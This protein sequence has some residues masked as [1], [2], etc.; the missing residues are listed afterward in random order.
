MAA[1]EEH[2]AYKAQL[3]REA[4]QA[5]AADLA[6]LLDPAAGD[7]PRWAGCMADLMEAAHTAYAE[8]CLRDAD[9]EPLP[10]KQI[11]EAACARLGL[12][13]PSN[14]RSMASRAGNRKGMR[15]ETL[16]ARYAMRLERERM[17]AG[18]GLQPHH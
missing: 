10:F 4:R 7:A 16:L 11:V 9:G 18:G 6:R 14:P 2:K 8:G 17:E 12:R 1:T 3:T 13:V 15:R 5:M